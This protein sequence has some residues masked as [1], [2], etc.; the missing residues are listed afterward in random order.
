MSIKPIEIDE[1]IQRYIA[2][3][4]EIEYCAE[5][6]VARMGIATEYESAKDYLEGLHARLE[7][8]TQ[9]VE[10]MRLDAEVEE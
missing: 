3:L 8:L 6:L 5:Q 7:D 4:D 2:A 9:D 10:N 1:A